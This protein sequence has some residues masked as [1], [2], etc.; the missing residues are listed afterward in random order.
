MTFFRNAFSRLLCSALIHHSA[1]YLVW[2]SEWWLWLALLALLLICIGVYYTFITSSYKNK[3]TE[4]VDFL[5][6]CCHEA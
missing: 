2:S 1:I 6:L 4:L 5:G 3:G